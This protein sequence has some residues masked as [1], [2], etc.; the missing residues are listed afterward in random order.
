MA[1]SPLDS[2]HIAVILPKK[3]A[4]ALAATGSRSGTPYAR[5]EPPLPPPE[6]VLKTCQPAP[7]DVFTIARSLPHS[8]LAVRSLIPSIMWTCPSVAANNQR[9]YLPRGN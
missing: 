6:L 4:A 9:A 8:S 3:S 7:H 2:V 5:T 1:V